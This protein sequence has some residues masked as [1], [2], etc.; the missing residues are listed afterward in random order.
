MKVQT[1]EDAEKKYIAAS[2]AWRRYLDQQAKAKFGEYTKAARAVDRS[3]AHL[4][5]CIEGKRGLDSVRRLAIKIDE[6]PA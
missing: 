6:T 2:E 5:D 4:W 1:K 3:R